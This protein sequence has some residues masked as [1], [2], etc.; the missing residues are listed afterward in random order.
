MTQDGDGGPA[1]EVA[2]KALFEKAAALDNAGALY[3]LGEYAEEGRA[4]AKDRNAAI[5]FYRKSAALGDDDA[6]DALKRLRC[7][8]ELKDKNGKVAGAICLGE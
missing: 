5:A 4:G 2:A 7:P 6:R 3:M 1:D 8:F